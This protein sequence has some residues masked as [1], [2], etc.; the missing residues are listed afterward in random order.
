MFIKLKF[1]ILNIGSENDKAL[2]ETEIDV[3]EGVKNV[4]AN[5][6]KREID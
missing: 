2:L 3:L 5:E 1:K 6:K 4:D